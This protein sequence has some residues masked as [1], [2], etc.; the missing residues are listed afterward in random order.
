MFYT[1][2]QP[3]GNYIALRGID[4]RGESFQKKVRYEPTLFVPSQKNSNWK[5]LDGKVVSPVNWG[6]MKEAKDAMRSYGSDVFGVEQFQYSFISDTYSGMIDYDMSK[7]KIA[8]IDLECSSEHGFPNIREANETILAISI[9]I[10]DDFK[11]YAC[12]EYSPTE[13]VRYIKC[14]NEY[15]LLET[16][17][18]DWADNYPDI[19]T[20][21]NTRFFDIPY[22][23]NRIRKTLGDKV[24]NKLSPWGWF[25]ENE[26]NLMGGRKQ[27]VYDLVGISSIDYMD[28][29][30]K[31]TY[32]T[33]N[34][35]H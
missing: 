25:R 6:S 22:L 16:F 9:K 20:G 10:G 26:V 15:A 3:F 32:T 8:Y 29:Y 13:G 24:A 27:Q 7:V 5:T 19:V 2:V 11:T 18:N 21:W 23:V 12:G 17:V 4:G 31:F 14:P 33:E 1:N 35:M 34:H 28:A 30:G